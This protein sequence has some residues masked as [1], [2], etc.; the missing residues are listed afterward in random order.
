M[1][2]FN[3]EILIGKLNFYAVRSLQHNWIVDKS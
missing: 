2:T 1:V 3:E